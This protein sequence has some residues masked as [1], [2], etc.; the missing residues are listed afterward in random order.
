MLTYPHQHVDVS[1]SLWLHLWPIINNINKSI[2]MKSTKSFIFS[3]KALASAALYFLIATNV[4]AQTPA[5]TDPVYIQR[6]YMKVMP[7]MWDDYLK[8]EQVWKAV[9]QR[10]KDEGKILGWTLYRSIYPRG[11][12]DEVSLLICYSS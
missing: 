1:L 10:R 8:A 7:G 11:G 6:G 12:R 4:Q 3:L 2:T 5:A 9:H